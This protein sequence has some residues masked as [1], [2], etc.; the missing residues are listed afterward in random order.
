MAVEQQKT[1]IPGLSPVKAWLRRLWDGGKSSPS[2]TEEEAGSPPVQKWEWAGYGVLLLAALGMR[3]W[4]LGARALHHDESLHS[5]FSWE[6]YTGNGFRHNPMMHGPFQFEAN[7]AIFFVFGDSDYTSRLLYALLGVALVV[8]PFFFRK[9]LG[10]LG[11]KFTS[12]MLAF[13]PALL[14]FSRFARNDILMAVWTLGL[15]MSMWRYIDE[16]KNRYLYISAA[17]LALAFATKETAYMVTALLGLFTIL[18]IIPRNWTAIVSTVETSGVSPPV[19]IGRLTAATWSAFRREVDLSR[20]SRPASFLI[21]LMTITLPQWSA[22]F[23]VLQDTP[24]LRWTNLVLANPESVSPIGAPT[25]GGVVIAALVVALLLA[26]SAYLGHRWNWSVWWR[27]AV[28]FYAI[29]LLLYTTFFTHIVGAGSGV[30][31]GLAYWMVQ[32]GEARGGQP[33]YYYFVLTSIYEFLPFLFAVIAGVY[34][35]RRNSIFGHFLVYWAIMTFILY[36]IASEK[37]PWLLVNIA[38]PLIVISGKFLGDVAQ[39]IQWRRMVT[40]GAIVVLPGI[41]VFLFLLWRLAFF[42]PESGDVTDVI[43]PLL[44]G[45]ALLALV[46][47]GVSIARRSGGRNFAS[48]AIIPVALLL[49]GLTIKT[50]VTA[51]FKNGDVPVE[52][53]IYTQT[54]P[55]VPQLAKTIESAAEV[56]G[57]RTALTITIDQ[58][59]G[60]TWPWAWYLRD[61]TN[62]GYPSYTSTPLEEAPDSSLLLLHSKFQEDAEELL[63]EK[64]SEGERIKHRWWFPEATYRD[65][66]A[67][68][69]LKAFVDRESWR[70]AMDYFLYRKGIRSR[71]GSEDAYLY[72]SEDLLCDFSTPR[73]SP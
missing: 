24:L 12:A 20:V 31:Q 61:Y 39:A 23:S 32:Q 55:D 26:F 2:E 25:G 5:Y 63:K 40:S 30:W 51:S 56:T 64:Y 22:L 6:L 42:E 69:F 59:S 50:G 8:L 27:S 43:V 52:M 37:M 58:T 34:Y 17:L 7:A 60:F 46:G 35:A 48:L 15:V 65:L 18:M 47:V 1:G 36:T 66:T 14:Y 57:Q 11:A 29:W 54:S 13:S 44:L 19:A 45:L 3:L 4:D 53:I 73:A 72:C 41:L 28:V 21:L 49:I 67:G 70:T 62:V 38:L 33:W 9:R 10:I 71:L 68:K 16:G